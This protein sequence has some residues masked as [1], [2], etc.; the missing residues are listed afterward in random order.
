MENTPNDNLS[1]QT[2]PTQEGVRSFSSFA[3][4]NRPATSLRL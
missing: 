3:R 4:E 2:S 1:S